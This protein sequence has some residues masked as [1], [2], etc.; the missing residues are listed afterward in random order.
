MRHATF[1]VLPALVYL[2]GS[3]A[4]AQPV[5]DACQT[6]QPFTKGFQACRGNVWSI[7]LWSRP[8]TDSSAVVTL[9]NPLCS[10]LPDGPLYIKPFGDAETILAGAMVATVAT[11]RAASGAV[12]LVFETEPLPGGGNRV[13]R[14]DYPA[15]AVCGA[16]FFGGPH[17]ETLPFLD[18]RPGHHKAHGKPK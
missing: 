11:A 7:E 1:A 12:Y 5:P 16:F 9:E 8:N 13:V 18:P 17:T 6:D 3:G 2:I 10:K 15:S 14:I 4:T